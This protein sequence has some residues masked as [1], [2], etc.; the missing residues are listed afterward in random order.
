MQSSA[1]AVSEFF[2]ESFSNRGLS[3][4]PLTVG[5]FTDLTLRTCKELFN[6]FVGIAFRVS[7]RLEKKIAEVSLF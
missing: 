6:S 4:C 7:A 1:A 3:T 2:I 5:L